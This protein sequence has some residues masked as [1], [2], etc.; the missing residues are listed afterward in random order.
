VIVAQVVRA[1]AAVGVAR[2]GE[3][4][5]LVACSGGADSVVLAHAAV[6]AL[7]ARRVVLGHVD[8]AVRAGSPADAA[9]VEAYAAQLG[10]EVHV[11]RLAPGPDDEA[12]LREARYAALEAQRVAADAAWILT[13]HSADDQAETV[14]L[15]LIRAPHPQVLAGMPQRRG[16]ILRPLLEVPRAAIRAYAARARLEWRE[17]PTNPD[18][19]W[20]RNR[21][22]KELLPLIEAR[23]RAG[24]AARLSELAAELQA[25]EGDPPPAGR[26]PEPAPRGSNRPTGSLVVSPVEIAIERRAWSGTPLPAGPEVALFDADV[27]DRLVVRPIRPGDRIRPMGLGGSKKLQDV[28]VD[29][30]VPREVRPRLWVAAHPGSGEVVWVPGLARGEV[31]P[32]STSTTQVWILTCGPSADPSL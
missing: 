26:V 5:V 11:S 12:R 30:K 23:Y 7:G 25:E 10:A 15:G 9:W 4:R 22:R 17:D 8:H 2:R 27:L 16:V 20:L 32:I 31:A 29:A 24:F 19:R 14:L 18:P 1:L 3:S 13:A 6:V 21:L 28:L